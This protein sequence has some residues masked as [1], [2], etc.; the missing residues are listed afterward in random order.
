MF[1]AVYLF[2]VQ[3]LKC[4][5]EKGIYRLAAVSESAARRTVGP[6]KRMV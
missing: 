4:F 1:P 2:H 6:L 5:P 3:T